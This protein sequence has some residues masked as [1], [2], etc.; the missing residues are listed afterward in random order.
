MEVKEMRARLTYT[1]RSAIRFTSILDIQRI[2]ERTLRRAG[3]KLLYSQGFH[4]QVKMQQAAPLPL[5]FCGEEEI[6]DVWFEASSNNLFNK[7]HLNS[8][9]PFGLEI[10]EIENIDPLAKSLQQFVVSSDYAITF[11]DPISQDELNALIDSINCAETILYRKHNGKQYDIKP[12]IFSVKSDNDKKEGIKLLIS[13]SSSPKAMARPDHILKYFHYEP[14][15][16]LITRKKINFIN[17]DEFCY[18]SM[19]K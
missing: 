6:I 16:T 11:F 4:P 5:G 12:L 8:F 10:K 3:I 17:H 2:W 14:S 7:N 9:L 15:L 13:L 1:K 18:S 19:F